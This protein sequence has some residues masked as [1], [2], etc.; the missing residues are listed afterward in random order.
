MTKKRLLVH[1]HL[2]YAAQADYFLE[3]LSHINGCEWTLF[4]TMPEPRPEIEER[5]RTMHSD[6]RITYPDNCGYDLWPF[7]SVIQ[8]TDLDNWDY[9]LKLH[10]K[11]YQDCACVNGIRY[12]G[13]QWRDR[14]VDTF[15]KDGASFRKAAG[16]LE[17]P[18]TG[19]VCNRLF[20]KKT[21]NGLPEDLTT[22]ENELARLGIKSNDRHFCAGCMFMAKAAPF[23]I[24]QTPLISK[25]T[26]NGTLKSHTYGTMAHTYERILSI[27][28]TAAGLR[29]QPIVTDRWRS[30]Y[31]DIVVDILQPG[32]EQIFSLRR[33]GDKRIK[34]LTIFGIN[35][36]LE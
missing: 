36:P 1:L 28:V 21:S 12:H 7:I 25:E 32:F 20:Y 2:F 34:T 30:A 19:M 22:L 29:I 18:G 14:T 4:L 5:F 31:I 11:N 3:K 23:K 8:S 24:L 17:K 26:F 6:V 15:L 35:I 10:S 9:I 27:A 16:M 33:I 13:Y